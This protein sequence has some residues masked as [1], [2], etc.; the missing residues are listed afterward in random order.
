MNLSNIKSDLS[1]ADR[2]ARDI[3]NRGHDATDVHE[4]AVAIR[5]LVH[6]VGGLAEEV[7]RLQ[8]QARH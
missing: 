7:D 4:L 8:I 3:A 2:W 6:A 1:A 5:K